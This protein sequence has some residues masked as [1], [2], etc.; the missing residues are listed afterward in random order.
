MQERQFE[1]LAENMGYHRNKLFYLQAYKTAPQLFWLCKWDA[2]YPLQTLRNNN[3]CV[4]LLESAQ[5]LFCYFA[6]TDYKCKTIL[7]RLNRQCKLQ[8]HT[9]SSLTGLT[10]TGTLV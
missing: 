3:P 5:G 2:H 8:I 4:T 6:L 7:P 1:P 10:K 9:Q